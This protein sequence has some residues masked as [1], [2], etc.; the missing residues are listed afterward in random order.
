MLVREK[1]LL[2]D[3][4]PPPP[5]AEEKL[6]EA[7]MLEDVCA[8]EEADALLGDKELVEDELAGFSIAQRPYVSP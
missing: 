8:L 3:D 2:H 1:R 7:G 5:A 6:L 4:P